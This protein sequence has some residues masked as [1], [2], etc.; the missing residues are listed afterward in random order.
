[1]SVDTEG[2]HFMTFQLLIAEVTHVQSFVTIT[3]SEM[4][5]GHISGQFAPYFFPA[6]RKEASLVIVASL[7]LVHS[8][9]FPP[10]NLS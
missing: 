8:A 10:P 4:G 7:S 9:T 5:V 1:M 2:V 6:A 3:V